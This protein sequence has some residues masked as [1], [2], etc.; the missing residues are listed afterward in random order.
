MNN[1][2]NFLENNGASLSSDIAE[3]VS[4]ITGEVPSSIRRKISRECN[5]VN[6]KIARLN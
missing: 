5:K 3:A 4:K 6:S 1:I 2:I